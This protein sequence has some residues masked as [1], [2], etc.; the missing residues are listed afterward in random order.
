MERGGR[1]YA[2]TL[3]WR[4]HQDSPDSVKGWIGP[5]ATLV[6]V[7]EAMEVAGRLGL[8]EVN[9]VFGRFLALFITLFPSLLVTQRSQD[10][11][12]LSEIVVP[13]SETT[14]FSNGKRETKIDELLLLRLS[15]RR[16]TICERKTRL[17]QY[18]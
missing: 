3:R 16:G 9:K 17:A 4:L 8:D 13:D 15:H 14:L 10:H 2:R 6:E 5:L 1:A 18:I 12:Q 7:A 11:S